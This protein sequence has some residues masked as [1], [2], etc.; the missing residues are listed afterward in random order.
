MS[1]GNLI[2]TTST[3]TKCADCAVRARA[4]FQGVPPDQLEWT[5]KYRHNQFT[6]KRRHE[7]FAE[8]G[9]HPYAYTLYSG[10]LMLSKSTRSGNRQ[11]L[12][13][14]LPGD[15]IG[16][17]TR[18]DGPMSYSAHAV[19][20]VRVCA[21]PKNKLAVMMKDLASRM[22]MLNARDIE[23]TQQLLIASSQNSS[24][25]VTSL[26]LQL[27]IRV[28]SLDN[29]V[30]ETAS[31][32][33]Q[34]PLSQNMLADALGMTPETINRTLRALREKGVLDVRSNR[35]VMIDQDLAFEIS[36]LDPNFVTEQALL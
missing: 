25:R 28:Q 21:F 27:Y 5:Q 22:A 17:Q 9:E 15:F 26:L 2:S 34:F 33:I 3:P 19:T 10:W 18:L 30:A 7:L 24:Q 20:D 23:L 1:K 32:S 13:F 8:Q 14:A 35:L 12:R 11:I 31:N 6:L 4:L 16:F 36:E 29:L